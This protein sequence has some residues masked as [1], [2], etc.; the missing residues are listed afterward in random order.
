MP[1][2][3]PKTLNEMLRNSVLLHGDRTAFKVKKQGKFVPITYKEFYSRVKKFGTGLLSIG[4]EKF[5][6]IG[7]VSDNRLEWIIADMAIIGL[8]AVDVPCS[9]DS[10]PHDIYF[11]L[12][13]SDAKAA[14]LEGEKQF[15]KFYSLAKDLPEIKNI[16]L[17]DKIKVFSEKEDVPEW[18]IPIGFQEDGKISKKFYNELCS[19]IKNNNRYI[20]LSKRT[21]DYLDKYLEKDINLLLKETHSS[22]TTDLAKNKILGKIVIIDKN[23]NETHQYKVYYFPNLIQIG[24]ELLAQGDSRFSEISKSCQPDDL[25]TIIYTS[26]TTADPK[27]VMLTNSNFMHNTINAPKAITINKDDNFL[28]ILPSWHVY[29]RT[30]EYCTLYKGASTAYS[31]PYKQALLPDLANEKPSVMVSV[32]RIWESVYKGIIDNIGKGSKIQKIIFNWAIK[33]GEEYKEAEGILNGTWPLFDRPEYSPEELAQARKTVKR[34]GWKYKLAEKLVFKK[35]RELTGGRLRFAISGGGALLENI[36]LFFA[37]VGIVVCEGYGLT[38][39]SPS[40]TARNPKNLIMF[41]VGPPLPEVEIKIVDK[42]NLEKELPNGEIGIVLV[43]GPMVMKGYYKNE[44][45]TREVIKDGWFNTGDLGKKTY[46]GKYLKI[47]G[48]IKDTIVLR[49]GE[50][51]EPLPLEDKLKESDYINTV[52]IVGQDKP[53]LGA[54]IVPDFETL[55]EYAEK[56]KIKYKNIDK[57][58]KHPKVISL[59]QKEQKRL[60]SKEQ[61]FKPYETV[62]GIALLPHEFTVEAGEMTETLKM[63]RFKIHK[64]YKEEIDKICG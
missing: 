8:R 57:L 51:V 23:F 38:E 36:D 28:S 12:H 59:Y 53:R 56:E 63:K 25:V 13:H 27:G 15:S 9:G 49:G 35:I 44:E 29:E 37:T 34:L 1:Q 62:M 14:I 64:K 41:T 54:L 58:I 40:L 19:L 52:I 50:N 24:E 39:T 61:G 7:L 10:S 46:N 60:I 55:K 48:R 21:K 2:Q 30:V 6:H 3:I 4:I 20:F 45:K 43:K 26:G 16:I 32:P 42:D 22:E 47:V 11:K 5:D 18:A 17:L 31:K 33:V